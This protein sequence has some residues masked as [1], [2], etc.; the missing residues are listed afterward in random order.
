MEKSNE[1]KGFENT[2]LLQTQK[3]SELRNVL[4][5]V[6]I[7]EIKYVIIVQKTFIESRAANRPEPGKPY[8]RKLTAGSIK[9]KALLPHQ[10][11][12]YCI[13]ISTKQLR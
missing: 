11:P 3:G 7:I 13:T 12:A 9:T 5:E 10:T 1:L 8:L 2:W 4:L 6:L